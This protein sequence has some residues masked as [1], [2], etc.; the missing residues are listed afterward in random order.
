[1]DPLGPVTY[2]RFVSASDTEPQADGIAEINI[3]PY[4][5]T[6][7]LLIMAQPYNKNCIFQPEQVWLVMT[8]TKLGDYSFKSPN[9]H[10]KRVLRQR[11]ALSNLSILTQF[12]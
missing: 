3:N 12:M 11:H 10:D 8:R 5:I 7:F 2:I 4:V 6:E 1:M 9:C